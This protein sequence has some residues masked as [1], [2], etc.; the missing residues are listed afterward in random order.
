M[1][2]KITNTDWVLLGISCLAFSVFFSSDN[3]GFWGMGVGLL[4]GL[5]TRWFLT[6]YFE[7]KRER[8]LYTYKDNFYYVEGWAEMKNPITRGWEDCC[9]YKAVE[10]NKLYVRN[11]GEFNEL[12]IEV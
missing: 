6:C 4:I 3:F 11:A 7:P 12:F 8:Q 9:I 1:R 10:S 5:N 2:K